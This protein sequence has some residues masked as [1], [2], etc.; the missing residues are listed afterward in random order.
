[1]SYCTNVACPAQIQRRFE[2]FISRGGMDIRGL[3]E[4]WV[5]ILFQNKLVHD[6]AD[7]YS[8]T[9]EQLL[10]LER[11]AD[12]SADNLLAAIEKSKERP[13]ERV[14]FAIGV[15]HVGEE[16]AELLVQHFGSVERLEQA[17]REELMAI[18]GVGPK[19]ADSIQAFFKQETNRELIEKLR[20]AGVR[21]E[22]ETKKAEAQPL[23]GKS[24][25][26]TGAL[27]SLTREEAERRIKELGGNTTSSVSRKTD[28]LVVGTDPGSKL[29]KA[30]EL[31]TRQLA[32]SEFL[33][34]LEK[35]GKATG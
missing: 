12:K 9:K 11:M 2:H 21:L 14:L 28:Y 24:F 10:K 18:P 35:P 16:T 31:G 13:L 20:K 8:L 1:M 15:T 3:G 26:L 32:E 33:E 5:N 27:Q 23:A 4:R 22:T 19:L 34:L 6:V 17:S 7:V 25:V 30:R 29:E